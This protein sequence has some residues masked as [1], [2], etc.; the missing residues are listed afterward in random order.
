MTWVLIILVHVGS[1]GKSD[2]NSLTNIPGFASPS[3]C[4]AAGQE[5]KR[6]VSGT[7]KELRYVCVA[8]KGLK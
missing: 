4:D 5:A 6:L 8:Q 1:F 7:V 2:S 3:E